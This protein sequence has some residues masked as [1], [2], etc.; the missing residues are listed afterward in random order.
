LKAICG[1]LVSIW[2]TYLIFEHSMLLGCA[3]ALSSIDLVLGAKA[4][5]ADAE[6]I[7][8]DGLCDNPTCRIEWRL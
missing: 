3:A 8:T 2:R 4:G 5:S 1:V 6:I 7:I